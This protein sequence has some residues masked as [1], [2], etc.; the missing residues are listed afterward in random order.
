[1][2]IDVYTLIKKPIEH[3]T[4]YIKNKRK[5]PT[6]SPTKVLIYNVTLK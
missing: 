6:K 3:K 4:F 5:Y 1:M 2:L